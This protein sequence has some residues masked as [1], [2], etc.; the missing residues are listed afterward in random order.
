MR[1]GGVAAIGAAVAVPLLRRRLRIPT[2]VTVAAVAA[3]PLALA[4]LQPRTKR[5]D[6]VLF[7]LQM[8]AFTVAHEL[9]YDDPERLRARLRSR[10]PIVSDRILGGGRLPNARLQRAIG[11][12]PRVRLVNQ[13][14]TWA[15]WLWFLEP[16]IALAVIL[17]R[18]PERFPRAGRQMAAVFDLGCAV[19]FA[20]PTAP[21]WWAAEQG[22]TGEEVRRIMVEVGEETW[23]S[24]WPKMYDALGGNPWAAMPSLHFATSV[25]AALALAE[26]GKVEGALGWTYAGTLGFA[27]VYLG[28]HYVTDLLAGAALVAAVRRG[29]ALAEPLIRGVNAGLQRLERIASS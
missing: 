3:G 20:V 26:A 1:A 24:A 19:Y 8:W 7:A 13:V 21:P 4:V 18:H 11:R 15:H 28:E 12:L 25:T 22:L 29:E 14:L 23:G 17:T 9:P 27:L 2:P 5:R 16:Y 6:V 10:Y